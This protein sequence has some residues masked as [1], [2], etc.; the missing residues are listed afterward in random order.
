MEKNGEKT[1]ANQNVMRFLWMFSAI[2]LMGVALSFLFIADMGTDPL[3][4]MNR[5]LA[6]VLPLSFGNCQ[7]ICNLVL[8]ILMIL[9]QRD[10]IGIGTVVN[11]VLVGYIAEFFEKVWRSFVSIGE[12]PAMGI[13]IGMLI[14]GMIL[15]IITAAIYMTAELG[16]APY[17]ALPILISKR[18]KFSFRTVR[19]MVDICAVAIGWICGNTP[20]IMTVLIVLTIGPVVSW[21]GKH[22]AVKLFKRETSFV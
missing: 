5:G 10:Q 3:S 8:I 11:M 21:F 20:G 12:N 9:F 7:L 2:V 14:I 15:F 4:T 6:M 22:V 13:R 17:D 16:T 19:M 18:V 1:Q